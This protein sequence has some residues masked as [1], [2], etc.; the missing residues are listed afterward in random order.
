M[1]A[2]QRIQNSVPLILESK[3]SLVIVF[4][5]LFQFICEVSAAWQTTI[6]RG[7]G[8]FHDDEANEELSPLVIGEDTNV[9]TSLPNE[10]P[11][12]IWSKVR[13]LPLFLLFFF[14]F[15]SFCLRSFS[16]NALRWPSTAVRSRW[17]FSPSC[18]TNRSPFPSAIAGPISP[19]TWGPSGRA[20][21]ELGQL[22]AVCLGQT[23][24][25]SFFCCT[26]VG[27]DAC[28]PL[29]SEMG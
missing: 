13:N 17:T 15:A 7:M 6:D 5:D 11:H 23:F 10:G 29:P 20:S 9:S 16:G 19:V 3:P 18:C 24:R 14:P 22:R 12:Q 8:I 25:Q 1:N 26:A 27:Q 4:F 2:A 28:V 21:G